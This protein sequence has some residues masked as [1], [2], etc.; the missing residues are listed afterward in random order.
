MKSA[1][2]TGG[3]YQP[4]SSANVELIHDRALQLLE[5]VGMTY[6][7]GLDHMLEMV[8]Q[9]GGRVDRE[10]QRI[11][12]PRD[13]ITAKVAQSPGRFTLH[14]RD[15]Q[16]DLDLGGDRVYCGTGGTA[17]RVLDIDT[18]EARQTVLQDLTNVAR[19]T[20]AMQHIH[21]F[22][23][24]CVPHDVPVEN[25]DVNG[26]FAAMRGTTKH[27]MLGCNS[28]RGLRQTF[29]MVATIVGG[30]EVLAEKP[31]FSI[32][33]CMII[34][35]LKFC[36]QSV[37]NAF[38]A[39][40]LGVPTTV[41]SAPMSGSTAPMT[42]AGTLL[43]T[44]AEEL[45]GITII[46][47]AHPG[48]KVLYGGLPAMA[49]MASMGYQGGAV[50][51]GMM[52]AAIHQLSKHVAVPN[53]ASS[54]LSDSKLPD[55]Q[56]GWEKTY[57]TALSVLGGCNYIHHAAGMLESML[58]IA[59]EQYI[60]DDEIIGQAFK[61]LQ[62][63]P[64]DETHLAYDNIKEVGPGGHYI[65]SDFTY[66][67]MRSEY[68]QG[69]GVSDKSGRKSWEK[70]GGLDARQRAREMARHIL[71][72]PLEENI[73]VAIEQQIRENFPILPEK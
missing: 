4:L 32:S 60:M 12:F 1:G 54:G 73:P 2:M 16:N 55:E 57:T 42:M 59:Y 17:L 33:S 21:F 25:Y 58:G 34:S 49:D 15:G 19:I 67:H 27:C 48:A 52:M 68:F 65:M 50:E 71:A 38:T 20:D 66:R 36:T 24:C 28:D 30:R 22:Q 6:E 13:L 11:F 61:L 14:S 43:Q 31:V 56:A 23:H 37:K 10:Q 69:N 39:A 40:E 47:I 51:V 35:P 46:Q 3:L 63:I 64:V 41:T 26:V 7:A 18:G 5:E 8:A 62:G 44:H 9:A 70:N 45:A 72:Q 53:Y 29:D